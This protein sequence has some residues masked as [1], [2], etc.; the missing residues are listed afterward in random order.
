[1]E[2]RQEILEKAQ[3]LIFIDTEPSQSDMDLLNTVTSLV[4]EKVLSRIQATLPEI[5]ETP[6]ELNTVLVELIIIR[7]NR[8]GSEGMKKETVDGHSI[9][10]TA[11]EHDLL[12]EV[13][14]WIDSQ[15]LIE[16]TP[17]IRFL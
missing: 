16:R 15:L 10:Y 12:A 17:R 8:I 3:K 4:T 1:M 7:F 2:I 5:T 11:S 13:D 14:N 6:L 9:E